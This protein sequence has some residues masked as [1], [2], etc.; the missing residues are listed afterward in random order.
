MPYLWLV[1]S[2]CQSWFSLALHMDFYSRSCCPRDLLI[3]FPILIHILWSFVCPFHCLSGFCSTDLIPSC[4]SWLGLKD[5]VS[6][7]MF[8]SLWRCLVVRL[9]WLPYQLL[10]GK[11][12]R[13]FVSVF[14]FPQSSF[15]SILH[16]S[17]GSVTQE[18]HFLF[19]GLQLYC[20]LWFF[21][22]V[23]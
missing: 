15:L 23:F 8:Q 12:W 17:S 11:D 13:C 5:L 18:I 9:L 10:H 16:S 2:C 4:V 6:I 1:L 14:W 7:F 22:S 19:Q 20:M 21:L 3:Q